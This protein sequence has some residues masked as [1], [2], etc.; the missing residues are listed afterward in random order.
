MHMTFK[1][2]KQTVLAFAISLAL[3]GMAYSAG[4]GTTTP[5]AKPSPEMLCMRQ[6]K[7][8][9]KKTKKCEDKKA[10]LDQESIFES[11][12]EYANAGQ[13]EEAL[14]IFALAPDQL[15]ARILNMKGFSHRKLGQI[16]KGMAF[17][18]HSIAVDPTYTLVREYYGEALLQIGDVAAAQNQLNTIKDICQSDNCEPYQ[19]L[20]AAISNYQTGNQ[21][22]P[23]A[24][25]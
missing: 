15:D 4:G 24:R 14:S 5:V 25:W 12:R 2:L 13:Y 19:Q 16:E 20:F 22:Q 21:N 8:Y 10:S 7:V 18:K 17:Y 9:N 6:G 23:V 1:T 11:G 3:P